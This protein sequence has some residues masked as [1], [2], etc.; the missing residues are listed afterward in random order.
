[1]SGYQIAGVKAAWRSS[2]M[3]LKSRQSEQHGGR[4]AGRGISAEGMAK[5]DSRVT[6]KAEGR[7]KAA[8]AKR[9]APAKEKI[10]SS[11]A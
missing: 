8:S 6:V 9:M 11:V 7:A 10:S 5:Y 1:M 4:Q 3:A 2:K